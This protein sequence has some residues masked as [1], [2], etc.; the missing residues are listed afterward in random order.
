[1]SFPTAACDKKHKEVRYTKVVLQGCL[2]PQ[3]LVIKNTKRY[4]IR[5]QLFRPSASNGRV[6]YSSPFTLTLIDFRGGVALSYFGDIALRPQPNRDRQ[7]Y[8]AT[9]AKMRCFSQLVDKRNTVGEMRM[10]ML[11]VV[12]GAGWAE[13][14]QGR[15]VL[16]QL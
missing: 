4:G 13:L 16:Q 1:M 8:I 2:S 3:L 5:Q 9:S 10:D 14:W 7:I 12:F 15:G 11:F 6:P